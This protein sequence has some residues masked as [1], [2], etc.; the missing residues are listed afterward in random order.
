MQRFILF[1]MLCCSLSSAAQI[2]PE[3]TAAGFPEIRVAVTYRPMEKQMELAKAWAP[4][5]NKD[6]F[7]IYDVGVN[8]FTVDARRNNAFFYR[9]RGEM[10]SHDIVYSLKVTFFDDNTYSLKFAVKEIYANKVLLRTTVSE[11]FTPDGRLK[12][13]YTDVKPS[14]ELTAG[15]IMKSFAAFVE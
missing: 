12:Q 15:R 1:I 6:G 10:F 14:L 13:D 8:T 5:Y 3:L 9:N 4:Y 7:D 11:F 2:N